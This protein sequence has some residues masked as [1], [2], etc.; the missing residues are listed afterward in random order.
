MKTLRRLSIS[1]A[2]T[3]LQLKRRPALSL[4]TRRWFAGSAVPSNLAALKIA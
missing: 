4:T 3:R 2:D 1:H